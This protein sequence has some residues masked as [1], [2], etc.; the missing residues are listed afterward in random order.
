MEPLWLCRDNFIRTSV[1][2]VAGWTD[3]AFRRVAWEDAQVLILLP[4][5]EKKNSTT[6]PTPAINV[7]TGV[8]YQALGWASLSAAAKKRGASA[9]VIISAKYGA[10]R[11]DQL[12]ESYKE[13]IDNSAMRV[14]VAKVLDAIKSDLIVDCRSS[15]YKAVWH[16]P[17]EKTVEVR[18]STVVDGVRKVVTHMSKKTRGE[19]TR[20]LLQSRSMPKT[21]EDLYAIVSEKYPCALTP[22]DGVEPWV[23]EVIAV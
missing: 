10:V 19:I 18:V 3:N 11:P 7:Y 1:R 17:V 6:K 22:S 20:W 2:K 21:P 16:S 23:L 13:K 9:V 8:L 12:I 4:P 14:P 5:S 15:T